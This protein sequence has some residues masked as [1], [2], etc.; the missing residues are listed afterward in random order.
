MTDEFLQTA[1]VSIFLGFSG[2]FFTF[3]ITDNHLLAFFWIYMGLMI[4]IVNLATDD[5]DDTKSWTS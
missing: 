1:L 2:V 4:G 3:M 5:Q